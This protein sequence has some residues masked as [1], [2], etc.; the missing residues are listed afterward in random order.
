MSTS[1]AISFDDITA[2]RQRLAGV[3]HR[4]PVQRSNN[5]DQ[6]SGAQLFFKC[7]NFQRMGAF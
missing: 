6:R 7:E 4:T 1:L 2:A 3:A 5:A